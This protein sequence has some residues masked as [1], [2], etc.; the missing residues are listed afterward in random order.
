MLEY[1][2]SLLPL[3]LQRLIR[4]E[5][6]DIVATFTKT[7]DRLTKFADRTL[8]EAEQANELAAILIAEARNKTAGVDAAKRVAD[9]LKALLD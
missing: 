9:R 1:L 2:F 3:K 6:T 8:R 7:Q 5:L 4:P